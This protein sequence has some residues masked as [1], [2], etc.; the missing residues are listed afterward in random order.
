M[1]NSIILVK[2]LCSRSCRFSR[3]RSACPAVCYKKSSQVNEIFEKRRTCRM[4]FLKSNILSLVYRQEKK[5]VERSDKGD[6][7]TKKNS[8][9][10]QTK[11]FKSKLVD[12][13]DLLPKKF[14]FAIIFD[15]KTDK[16]VKLNGPTVM[17]IQLL[18]IIYIM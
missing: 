13:I 14:K 2:A 17:F 6:V 12:R 11:N 5:P 18:Y 9:I 10:F 4:D 15:N 16:N 7:L 1:A 8:E 3:I